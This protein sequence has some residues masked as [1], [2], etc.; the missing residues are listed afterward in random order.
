M[1]QVLDVNSYCVE[2]SHSDVLSCRLI[3]WTGRWSLFGS[4]VLCCQC[5]NGQPVEDAGLPFPHLECCTAHGMYP[6][7][8]LKEVMTAV[9]APA[10]RMSLR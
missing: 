6:W 9:A 4:H 2:L 5:L 1:A 3:G 8:E 7:Q 10:R